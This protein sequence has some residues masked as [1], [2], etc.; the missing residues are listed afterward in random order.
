MSRSVFWLFA[1]HALPNGASGWLEL[2]PGAVV[3]AVGLQAM[4]LFTAYFLGPKLM[5]ATQLY[6]LVGVVTTALFWFYLGGR[7][8]VAGATLN[9]EF[10]EKRAAQR[11]A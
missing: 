11:S 2:V 5:G 9:V 1:S 4:H 7:L 10:T 6:G 8:I 3:V